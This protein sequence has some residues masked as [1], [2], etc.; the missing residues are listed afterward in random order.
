M[1]DDSPAS[2]VAPSLERVI[3]VDRHDLPIGSAEKLRAHREGLL[4]RAFSV[5]VLNTDDEV[6]LQQRASD[7][8]HSGGL[9]SNTCCGHPRPGERTQVAARR[10]LGEEM[11][12]VC[13]LVSTGKLIYDVTFPNGLS[14]HEV[15]HVFTGRWSGEP[16]PDPTEVMGWRWVRL[17]DVVAELAV[18]PERFTSWFRLLMSRGDIARRARR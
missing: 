12:I 13:P 11:G 6:L 5:L 1:G 8:Y 16:R 18:A 2:V 7:K 17:R 10:R 14:E 4:H 15:L 3:L 9:W